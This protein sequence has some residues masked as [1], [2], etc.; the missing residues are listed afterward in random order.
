MNLP[1]AKAVG[2]SSV[3]VLGL[4]APAAAGD[5][6]PPPLEPALTING[7]Q[8]VPVDKPV[9]LDASESKGDIRGFRF[10]LDGNGS[11]ETDTGTTPYVDHAF[12]EPGRVRVRVLVTDTA[13][14]AQGAAQ[15]IEVAAPK[16]VV[17]AAKPQAKAKQNPQA[18]AEQKPRSKA[19]PQAH[20]GASSSVTIKDFSFG[21]KSI[22]IKAGD[23][24]TWTNTGQ[25]PHDASGSG[26]KIPVLTTGKSASHTF[27]TPGTFSY[28]CSIHPFMKGTVVVAG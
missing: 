22:S 1:S 17:V 10:D 28:I 16:P 3:L 24:V 14:R 27:N 7:A 12:S 8:P 6:A 18:K 15:T 2:L 25:A 20:A 13:G 23:T 11:Y 9:R 4:A 5:S 26:F 19:T 21:P